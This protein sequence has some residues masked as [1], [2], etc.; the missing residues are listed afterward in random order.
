M[1]GADCLHYC[2]PG[3]IDQWVEMF[4]WAVYLSRKLMPED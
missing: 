1:G 4:V 3:P 2:I